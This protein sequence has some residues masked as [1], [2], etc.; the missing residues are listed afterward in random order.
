M[1]KNS[2]GKFMFTLH[3]VF[4]F[5]FKTFVHNLNRLFFFFSQHSEEPIRTYYMMGNE[6]KQP[7]KSD[8]GNSPW[9]TDVTMSNTSIVTSDTS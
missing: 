4:G 9:G 5:A 6:V 8:E 7:L 3:M 2:E 1:E